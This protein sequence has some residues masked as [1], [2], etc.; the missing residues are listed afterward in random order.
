MWTEEYCC[1]Q[2]EFRC[3][4]FLG[5]CLYGK[6]PEVTFISFSFRISLEVSCLNLAAWAV[7]GIPITDQSRDDRL[8]PTW[9]YSATFLMGICTCI[10]LPNR[11]WLNNKESF[12]Q[13]KITPSVQEC[14]ALLGR[15]GVLKVTQDKMHQHHQGTWYANFLPQNYWIMKLWEWSLAICVLTSPLGDF[16]AQFWIPLGKMTIHPGTGLGLIVNSTILYYLSG[17]FLLKWPGLD[18]K[19]YDRPHISEWIL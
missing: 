7:S 6:K 12:F 4:S 9:A 2:S 15:T 17:H 10:R 19:L 11:G 14:Q 8:M 13:M 16:A 1:L 3:W 18:S 5:Q